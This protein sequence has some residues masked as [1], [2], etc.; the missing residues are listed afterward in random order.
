MSHHPALRPALPAG[1]PWWADQLTREIR[2]W[3]P[4]HPADVDAAATVATLIDTWYWRSLLTD[5]Q[6]AQVARQILDGAQ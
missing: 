3:G 1:N 4:I 2:A 5:E 6:A